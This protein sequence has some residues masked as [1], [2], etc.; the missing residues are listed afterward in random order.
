MTF[1]FKR[2]YLFQ[3][4]EN[5]TGFSLQGVYLIRSPRQIKGRRRKP[6]QNF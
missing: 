6:A 2:S 1:L 5:R 4:L 3:F